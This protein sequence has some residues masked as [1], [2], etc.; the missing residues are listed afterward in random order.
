[1][2]RLC[3]E[4]EILGEY[5]SGVI[6]PQDRIWV[7]EHLSSCTKCRKLIS[8]AHSVLSKEEKHRIKRNFLH[9]M[10]KNAWGILSVLCLLLSFLF[11]RYFLQFLL[12]GSLTALKWIIDSKSAKTLIMIHKAQKLG[13]EENSSTSSFSSKDKK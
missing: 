9:L 8:E 6:D 10:R 3:P 12:A 2:N 7:E 11:P 1:M 13:E 4:E 5:A